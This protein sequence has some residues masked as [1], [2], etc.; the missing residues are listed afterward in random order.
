LRGRGREKKSW[1]PIVGMKE[2]YKGR[3]IRKK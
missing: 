3:W 2:K 1:G